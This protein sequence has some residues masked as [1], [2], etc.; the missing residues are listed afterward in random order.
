MNYKPLLILGGIMIVLIVGVAFAY[1]SMRGPSASPGTYDAL[2]QCITDSGAKFY[3]A[4][5]CPHCQEQKRAFGSSANFLPYV[6]CSTPDGQRQL[7]VCT[8][9]EVKSY[10]TWVFANGQRTTGNIKLESLANLTGCTMP[11]VTDAAPAN[12]G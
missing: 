12:N 4:F 3:G 6:E 1:Q 5:W 2:A 9:A 10:P 7:E 8:T 11:S